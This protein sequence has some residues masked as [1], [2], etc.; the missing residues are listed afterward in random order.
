ML[1]IEKLRLEIDSLHV[2]MAR[3]F[4]QRLQLTLKIWRI[5]K[6]NQLS[7]VDDGREDFIIHQFD[8]E[9][10][11]SIEQQAL[12]SFFRSTIVETKKYLEAKL[13]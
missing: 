3:L 8:Q 13:K 11:D 12:Q 5:K 4:R 9:T 2:E 7:L 1:E 10:A 6:Q